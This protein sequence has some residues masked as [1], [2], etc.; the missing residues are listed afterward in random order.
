MADTKISAMTSA[1]ALDG[2]ELVP[3]VQGGANVKATTQAIADLAGAGGMLSGVT[4]GTDT[5]FVTIPGG[6]TLGLTQ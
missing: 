5:Y 3:V 4:T 6:P 1:A 2:T